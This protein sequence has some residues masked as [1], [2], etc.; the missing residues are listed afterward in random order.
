MSSDDGSNANPVEVPLFFYEVEDE[1]EG[2]TR[3]L[4]GYM[5]RFLAES[6]GLRSEAMVGEY[7]PDPDG[8][9]DPT[10][11]R[12]NPEFIAAFVAYANW[13]SRENAGL[14][15]AAREQPGA[16]LYLVDPRNENPDAAP[17]ESDVLGSYDVDAQGAIVPDSFAYNDEHLWFCPRSG[18]SGVFHDADFYRALHPDY[19]GGPFQ[20]FQHEPESF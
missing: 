18:I 2:K 10:T 15:E 11:F 3:H 12:R 1:N 17:P 13:K 16:R 14:Q 4:I 19:E 5:H 9:F 6:R 8:R 20:I 7:D